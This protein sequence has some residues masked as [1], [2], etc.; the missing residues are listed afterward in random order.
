MTIIIAGLFTA[1]IFITLDK[2]GFQ[3]WFYQE[4]VPRKKKWMPGHICE[5]CITF[6]ASFL[7]HLFTSL[8]YNLLSVIYCLIAGLSST[9][10][11][12]LVR[13]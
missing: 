12:Y 4:F 6:W 1:G 2:W 8:D 11:N 9:S 7:F 13:K 10:V 5:H 3:E